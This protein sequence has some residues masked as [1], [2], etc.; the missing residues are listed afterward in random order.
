MKSKSIHLKQGGYIEVFVRRKYGS[1]KFDLVKG[2]FNLTEQGQA[3]V[4]EL[5]FKYYNQNTRSFIMF[6]S[7]VVGALL[8]IPIENVE[9]VATELQKILENEKNLVN[10]CDVSPTAKGF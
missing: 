4:E 10:I 3:K 2:D 8:K 1:V 9:T 6:S 5:F 7:S